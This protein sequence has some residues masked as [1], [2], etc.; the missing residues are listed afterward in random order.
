MVLSLRR[1]LSERAGPAKLDRNTARILIQE[2]EE[3]MLRR[4]SEERIE[5]CIRGIKTVLEITE[6]YFHAE[7]SDE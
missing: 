3:V 2:M 4:P 7:P 1:T 5:T 6:D